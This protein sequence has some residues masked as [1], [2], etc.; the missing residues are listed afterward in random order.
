MV[1]AAHPRIA[2]AAVLPICTVCLFSPVVTAALCNVDFTPDNWFDVALAGFVEE[3]GCGEKIAVVGD[4]YGR[5][6]LPRRLVQQLRGFA[7][8]VEQAEIGMNVKMHELRLTH[9]PRF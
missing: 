6:L 4:G 8:T 1:G 2:T 5:H 3:I 9:G 7:C